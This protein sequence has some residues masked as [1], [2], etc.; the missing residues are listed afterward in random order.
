[1]DSADDSKL[2]LGDNK[3]I[4]DIKEILESYVYK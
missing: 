1:M 2:P 4:K 3:D